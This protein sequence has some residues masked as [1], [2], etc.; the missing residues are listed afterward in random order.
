VAYPPSPERVAPLTF[1]LTEKLALA[2][3]EDDVVKVN[4]ALFVT[5][6]GPGPP[7]CSGALFI[8]IEDLDPAV[9]NPKLREEKS[10]AMVYYLKLGFFD[11]KTL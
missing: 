3:K 6:T 5:S 9:S 7:S 2:V 10:G 4:G 1:I 11:T 8:M